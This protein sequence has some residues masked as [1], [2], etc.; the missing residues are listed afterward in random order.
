MTHAVNRGLYGFAR[1]PGRCPLAQ[2][3]TKANSLIVLAFAVIFSVVAMLYLRYDAEVESSN[4]WVRH[5]YVVLATL[6]DLKLAVDEAETGQRG[7]LLTGSA[8]YLA[9]Y[10]A[11]RDRVTLLYSQLKALTSDNPDEQQRLAE[12]APLIQQKLE[13]LAQT[14]ELRRANGI[15]AALQIVNSDHGRELMT[16]IR[17]TLDRMVATEQQLLGDRLAAN[18]SVRRMTAALAVI[19]GLTT[20]VLLAFGAAMLRAAWQRQLAAEA[21]AR[22][23]ATRLRVSLDSLSQGVAVFD[24]NWELINWNECYVELLRVPPALARIGAP[25]AALV[26]HLGARGDFLETEAQIRHGVPQKGSREPVVYER[27]HGDR[28]FEIRRTPLPA[29]GFAVTFS[30]ITAKVRAEKAQRD[31]QKMQALGALTGGVAH[32]FNNLLT[33]IGGS[34][35]L[36][37]PKLGADHAVAPHL[38]A[39]QRGVDRGSALTRQL[40]AF[41]RRQPLAPKP[42]DLNRLVGDMSGGMLRRAL[43]ERV[44][45]RFIE[46]AG[47]WPAF[48]DP[49]QVESAVLNLA[50]NAR[51]A[52][53]DGGKLTIETANVA[54]DAGYAAQNDEVTP[55]QYVMI[56]VSDTGTG[57][58][59]DIAARAFEP[60]FTTKAEGRVSGLG[61]AMVHGFAK[62]SKGHVKI[63]SEP[64]NGTTVKL[65][66]PR[67][68]RAPLD[69]PLA[70]TLLPRG[71]AT[72]LV[73]EDDA[74]VRRVAVAQLREL[75]YRVHEASDAE[76]GLRKFSEI[77]TLDLLLTDVVLPGRLRGKDLADLVRRANPSARILFMSG[78]TENAIVHDGKLDDGVMLL[79]KPFRS[80]EL[81]KMVAVALSR[82]VPATQSAEGKVV[83]LGDAQR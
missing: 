63:Y 32:D 66:L 28:V 82:G 43:G 83:Q 12:M 5:T 53:P 75:G 62:Q 35:D 56:A 54:L 69:E 74:D 79:I 20:I 44:D 45:V 6:K 64:G 1:W 42:L 49:N 81:A 7:F 2:L 59:A 78:Y 13:E 39:A 19:G 36:M 11:A 73:V 67:S 18:A 76:A 58:P 41:G 17:A 71:S 3:A 55:G 9:P 25:Y 33:V 37:T 68:Q 50:L 26:E 80:E 30:D 61:L 31:S 23:V 10:N 22:E 8:D 65:Y 14:I 47:L 4:G 51:D 29:G 48:A 57:M 16:G 38:A 27:S 52:M 15:E 60:F 40:L 77:E 72:V 24:A 70:P 46:S 21:H 34:L